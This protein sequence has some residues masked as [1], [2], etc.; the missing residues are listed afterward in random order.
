LGNFVA[1]KFFNVF[2]LSS[3]KCLF[4]VVKFL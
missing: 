3:V 4:Y 1:V 2:V